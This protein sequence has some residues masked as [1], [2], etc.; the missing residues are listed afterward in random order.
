[1]ETLETCG[2]I[3]KYP[4]FIPAVPKEKKKKVWLEGDPK[5]Y[6]W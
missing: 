5:K 2:M 6:H 1:M 4:M 3:I